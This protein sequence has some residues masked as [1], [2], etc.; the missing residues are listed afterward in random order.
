MLLMVGMFVMFE[1]LCFVVLC[2]F[3]MNVLESCVGNVF[4]G[5]WGLMFKYLKLVLCGSVFGI[6]VG[7][8]FGVGVDIVVW[9]LYVMSKKLLK[10]LEKFGIG[11]LEGIVELGVVNNLVLVGV[12][13]LVL[14][15]G[16][17]GDLIIVIVI[18]VFYMKNFNLGLMIF[19]DNLVL[20]YVI[21]LVFI[22]VNLLMLLLGFWCIKMVKCIFFILCGILMLLILLFCIVGFYVINN[23]VIDVGIM[24]VF[25]LLVYVMEENGFLVVLVVLGVVLGGMLEEYF[26]ILMIKFDG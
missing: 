9:M 17:L 24:L 8:L 1:V 20:M 13:I 19:V 6:L 16:I 22:L 2:D 14:V 15:F 7:V 21:F 23:S 25:G 18:G 3:V 12:W 10:E 5:M 11:Y 26:V 4:K